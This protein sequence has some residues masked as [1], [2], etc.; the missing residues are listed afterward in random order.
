[1]D[2]EH[3]NSDRIQEVWQAVEGLVLKDRKVPKSH[4]NPHGSPAT[5]DVADLNIKPFKPAEQKQV[6]HIVE[7][8][9]EFEIDIV[10]KEQLIDAVM[11]KGAYDELPTPLKPKTKYEIGYIMQLVHVPKGE[12]KYLILKYYSFAEKQFSS[13]VKD[14]LLYDGD[15]VQAFTLTWAQNRYQTLATFKHMLQC[16]GGLHYSYTMWPHEFASGSKNR[17]KTRT[18]SWKDSDLL[19]PSR[20]N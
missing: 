8:F 6:S 5:I 11:A 4:G 7:V 18:N 3:A 20:K 1:M 15:N 12:G 16:M 14:N 2:Y 13:V 9:P 10:A 17:R 19:Q